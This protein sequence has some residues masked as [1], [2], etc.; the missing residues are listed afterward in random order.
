MKLHRVRG[1]KAAA[2]RLLL[3]VL[4][5]LMLLTGLTAWLCRQL[6]PV[7]RTVAEATLTSIVTKQAGN[8]LSETESSARSYEALVDF[9]YDRSGSL[10]AVSTDMD[11]AGA[12]QSAVTNALTDSLSQLKEKTIQIPSGSLTGIPLLTGKGF[13]VPVTVESIISV[14]SDIR[15][16]LTEVGINQMLHRMEIVITTDIT[17]LVPGGSCTVEVESIVPLA[18]S[19]LL[20]QVSE[21]YTYFAPEGQS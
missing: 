18:E 16:E 3:I 19:L 21:S 15:S 20:G 5:I 7:I 11:A 1:P 6:K 12:L 8:A 10:V 9:Q 13:S 4:A 14:T 2:K 17:I